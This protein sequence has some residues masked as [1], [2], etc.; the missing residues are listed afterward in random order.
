MR[1]KYILYLS[2]AIAAGCLI[3]MTIRLFP[4][5]ILEKALPEVQ[6]INVEMIK[7]VGDRADIDMMIVVYNPTPFSFS[8]DSMSYL[9][10]LGDQEALRSRS[11]KRFRIVA[12]DTAS[13]ILSFSVNIKRLLST[14][15][16]LYAE[17]K[18]RAYYT[19]VVTL[20]DVPEFMKR[21]S[22]NFRIRRMAPIVIPPRIRLRKMDVDKTERSSLIADIEVEIVNKN[23]FSFGLEDVEYM[24]QIDDDDWLRGTETDGFYV[25]SRGSEIAVFPIEI[26]PLETGKTALDM[27][28]KGDDATYAF[29]MNANIISDFKI[30]SHSRIQLQANGKLKE[31]TGDVQ[32]DQTE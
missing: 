16:K 26:K 31:L 3:Y 15:E 14:V 1:L 2:I 23:A 8:V 27:T 25:P 28:T 18:D 11:P 12:K 22:L 30:F 17:G 21:D 6:S 7:I 32:R 13:I 29:K 4:E 10:G 9:I 24:L 5:G 20:H 19:L